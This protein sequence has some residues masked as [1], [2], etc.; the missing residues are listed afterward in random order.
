MYNTSSQVLSQL[1]FFI[2]L[3]DSYVISSY[4]LNHQIPKLII[5]SYGNYHLQILLIHSAVHLR[6][7]HVSHERLTHPLAFHAAT[8]RTRQIV[9]IFFKS[10]DLYYKRISLVLYR[11]VLSKIICPKSAPK[12][13][14]CQLSFRNFSGNTFQWPE[15]NIWTTMCHI[16]FVHPKQL[17][18]W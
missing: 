6:S 2:C 8:S 13:N 14:Y 16:K 3:I 15:S 17:N 5:V 11:Q 18:V 1:L 4:I 12:L 10:L 7:R 9:H